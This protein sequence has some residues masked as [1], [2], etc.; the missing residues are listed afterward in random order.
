MAYL[1]HLHWRIVGGSA[2]VSTSGACFSLEQCRGFYQT[3]CFFCGNVG[4]KPTYGRCSRFGIIAFASSLDQA[5]PITKTVE[6]AAYALTAMASWDQN[7]STSVNVH[8]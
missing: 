6:D 7:D 8:C 3:T 5:G 1:N 2:A 4:L